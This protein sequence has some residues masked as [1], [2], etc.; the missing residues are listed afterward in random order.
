MEWRWF[1]GRALLVLV[2]SMLAG[3][4]AARLCI[5]GFGDVGIVSLSCWG[6]LGGD[7]L[8]VVRVFA[9]VGF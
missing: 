4:E 9:I 6:W 8:G 5:N 2:V 3:F 1:A 7:L